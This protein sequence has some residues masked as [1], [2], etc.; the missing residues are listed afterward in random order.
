MDD[1]MNNPNAPMTDLEIIYEIDALSKEVESQAVQLSEL[2]SRLAKI[3]YPQ[4]KCKTAEDSPPLV[5]LANSIR[6]SRLRVTENTEVITFLLGA[7][8]L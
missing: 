1:E 4:T 6:S 8:Q 3:H 2:T 5:P 7:I